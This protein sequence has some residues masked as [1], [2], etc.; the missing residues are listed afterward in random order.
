[1]LAA[2]LVLGRR[3]RQDPGWAA[4]SRP[5]VL[6]AL[7][8][9]VALA[10]FASRVV[11]PWNGAVQ[12]AAVT[13]ALA[14][15]VVIAVHMLTLPRRARPRDLPASQASQRPSRIRSRP[16]SSF[17]SRHAWMRRGVMRKYA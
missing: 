17:S 13:L 3:F 16:A 6:L 15:E 4:V 1:M 2:P 9:A 14:A 8:S 12:R 7:G 11:E 5:V 10:V